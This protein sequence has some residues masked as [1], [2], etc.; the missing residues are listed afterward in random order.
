MACAF[1]DGPLMP[2]TAAAEAH[3]IAH[4]YDLPLAVLAF[5][6]LTI[7]AIAANPAD[8]CYNC[9]KA[10]A[11]L[12]K[13]E[14][15]DRGLGAVV[16]GVNCSDFAEDRPGLRACAEEG[17]GH[18]FVAAGI[19]KPEIRAIARG[20]GLSFAEKPSSAC[21]ASRVPYGEPL[22]PTV[23]ARVEEAEEALQRLGFARGRVRVHGRLARIEVPPAELSRALAA[24]PGLIPALKAVGFAYVALDLEGYR[25]GAMDEVLGDMTK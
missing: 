25:P 17:I 22:A 24:A 7:P 21:L 14:A 16:D 6:P 9:K 13:R 4:A 5:D 3:A 8:R 2:R 12:L 11:S 23:L 10:I 15:A 18:P 19:A 1:V 20:L